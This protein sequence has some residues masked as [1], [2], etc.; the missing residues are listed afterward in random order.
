MKT[1]MRLL[2]PAFLIFL[3]IVGACVGG[4]LWY[5]SNIDRSGWVE[6]E[7]IRLA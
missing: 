2:L 3:I 4:W 7:G 1:K 5:D 6:E